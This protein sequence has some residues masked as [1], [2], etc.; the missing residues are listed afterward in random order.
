MK[1][2]IKFLNEFKGFG[3]IT[4]E[5]GDIFFHVSNIEN[6]DDSQKLTKGD[7]VE[8]EIGEGKKGPKAIKIKKVNE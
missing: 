5:S 8:F 7:D 1:G 6:E 2:K 3:F 4:G